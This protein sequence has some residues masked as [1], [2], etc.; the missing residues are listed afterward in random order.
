MSSGFFFGGETGVHRLTGETKKKYP[1]VDL[2]ETSGSRP[3]E[4]AGAGSR[5]N[6]DSMGVGALTLGHWVKSLKPAS[7][8]LL[9]QS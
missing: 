4:P 8:R 9:P 6:A 3:F 2:F 1:L 5:G 7:P